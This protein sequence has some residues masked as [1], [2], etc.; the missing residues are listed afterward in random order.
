MTAPPA[1]LT[2]GLGARAEVLRSVATRAALLAG[3]LHWR[4]PGAYAFDDQVAALVEALRN[5]AD[6]LDATQAL[7]DRLRTTGGP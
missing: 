1:P 3:A 7:L 4:S 5:A 6:Q 2:A